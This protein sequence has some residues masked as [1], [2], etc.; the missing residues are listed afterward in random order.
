MDTIRAVYR[1]AVMLGTLVVLGMAFVAY[2]PPPEKLGP[3]IDCAWNQASESLVEWRKD[4]RGNKRGDAAELE[5]TPLAPAAAPP[6]TMTVSDRVEIPPPPLF[7]DAV[8][9]ANQP[10]PSGVQQLL[11]ELNAMGM[12]EHRLDRFGTTGQLYRFSCRV[13]YPGQVAMQQH[14]E[15]VAATPGEA[16]ANVLRQLEAARRSQTIQN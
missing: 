6:P 15:A 3:L 5:L 13:A 4:S 12:G 9:E 10:R 11:A 8:D 7:T 16:V 14:L 2:G 1:L